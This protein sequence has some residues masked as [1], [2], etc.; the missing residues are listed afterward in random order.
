MFRSLRRLSI[1][2]KLIAVIGAAG[3]VAQLLTCLAFFSYQS[4]QMQ[5][6]LRQDMSAV[7]SV[8]AAGSAAV[9]IFHDRQAALVNLHVAQRDSRLAAA[10]IYDQQGH[11][12][13]SY[14]GDGLSALPFPNLPRA[15]GH[16]RS[17]EYVEMFEPITHEGER[18]GTVYLQADYRLLGA[19]IRRFFWISGGVAISGMLLILFLSFHLQRIISRPILALAH[20]ARRITT[21][22][23]YHLRAEKQ[24]GDEVGEL[25]D[26]FNDM[27]AAIESRDSALA[28]QRDRLEIQIASRT[29]DLMNMNRELRQAK[30]KAEAAT[31]LKSDFLANMSHE[32]RTPMNGIIG[33]TQLTLSTDLN[34]EQRENLTLVQNS[35][36]SLLTVINDILDFSKVEAGKVLLE[37]S[38]F[39][40]S[41]AVMEAVRIL[42]L[43][44][45]ERGLNL[46]VRWETNVPDR[47]IGDAARL[48]QILLNLL[49]NAVKF[50]E[51]GEVLLRISL[52]H[53][54]ES[55][56]KLRFDITDTGIGIPEDRQRAIFDSFTQ[57]DGSIAR[58]FGGTGL[59]LAIS[60]RL[61]RLMGGEMT[62]ESQA[63]QGS[64][65]SFTALFRLALDGAA[66]T[67][68]NPAASK[69][70]L[71]LETHEFSRRT[72]HDTLTHWGA[73][74]RSN[75]TAAEIR[76]V[77]SNVPL[78][79]VVLLDAH[80]PGEN[81]AEMA[82]ALIDQGFAKRVVLMFR[83]FGTGPQ[84][85]QAQHLG[86]RCSL[87]KPVFPSHLAQL[88][89]VTP[90]SPQPSAFCS[91]PADAGESLHRLRILLAEDN[92]VN[93]R[94]AVRLL[95]KRGH[96][97]SVAA[98]GAEALEALRLYRFDLVLMDI[99]MPVMDGVETVTRIRELERSSG[100]HLPVIALTAHAMKD[101]EAHCLAAGMDGYVS[102]PIDPDE[103]FAVMDK[104]IS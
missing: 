49:G 31:R 88:L 27:L 66:P 13:A 44:A 42:A 2:R 71:L 60:L 51:Q 90:D 24:S 82:R 3:C 104:V 72:L 94:V 52:D 7:A 103:L 77:S 28:R 17:G 18:I 70:I 73:S 59:G 46:G 15:R 21:E 81:T 86:L 40:L 85:Q 92:A 26:A 87:T 91:T 97:V 56:V 47:L 48:R 84:R 23:C 8:L 65:F 4:I 35:A 33:L 58:R 54:G 80:I 12:F 5:E 79:D 16:Y 32:I 101:D 102:K 29:A 25:I 76:H 61:V 100:S 20:L 98:N 50:T 95:E 74:V 96:Q 55:G 64:H 1:Q 89:A 10:A 45:H 36:E 22:R 75:L 78:Y 34:R 41:E 67:S 14:Q 9:L 30:E 43:R 63:G 11:L 93:Q 6:N 62:V 38:P 69:K 83:A 19:N 68:P 53:A 57:A 99:Q 37:E 39:S